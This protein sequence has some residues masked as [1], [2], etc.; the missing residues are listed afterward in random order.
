MSKNDKQTCKIEMIQGIFAN[1]RDIPETVQ[2][3][4]IS[5]DNCHRLARE[6]W[7]LLLKIGSLFQAP[8]SAYDDVL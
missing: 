3:R 7:G 4:D 1:F 5:G 8:N 6:I 2:S